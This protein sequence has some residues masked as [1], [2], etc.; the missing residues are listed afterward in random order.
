MN[1]TVAPSQLHIGVE[2]RTPLPQLD[3][4]FA[5]V[6]MISH[7]RHT[8]LSNKKGS[9]MTGHG[10]R[11]T[12]GALMQLVAEIGADV[13]DFC[14]SMASEVLERLMGFTGASKEGRKGVRCCLDDDRSSL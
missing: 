6:D 3:P 9:S 14:T 5:N 13:K 8:F 4:A 7:H 1:P 2:G 11:S 12:T 10:V